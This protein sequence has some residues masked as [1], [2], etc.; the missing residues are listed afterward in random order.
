MLQTVLT[1]SNTSNNFTCIVSVYLKMYEGHFRS[2]VNV[3]IVA[4]SMLFTYEVVYHR[5]RQS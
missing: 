5:N 4:N 2:N 3:I 1:T